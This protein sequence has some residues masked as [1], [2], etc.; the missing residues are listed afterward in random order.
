MN[1]TTPL[2]TSM[3]QLRVWHSSGVAIFDVDT[4][5]QGWTLWSNMLRN[6]GYYRKNSTT[7]K[8]LFATAPL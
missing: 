4:V 8:V 5:E 6:D 3:Y 2:I 1:F 7:A